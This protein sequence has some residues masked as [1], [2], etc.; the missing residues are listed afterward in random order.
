[1]RFLASWWERFPWREVAPTVLL[2]LAGV[3]LAGNADAFIKAVF[4]PCGFV[5]G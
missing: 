5:W 4:G 3:G 2:A 1:M